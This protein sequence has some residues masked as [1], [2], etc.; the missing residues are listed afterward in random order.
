MAYWNKQHWMRRAPCPGREVLWQCHHFLSTDVEELPLSLLWYF[1]NETELRLCQHLLKP[2]QV[3]LHQHR[4]MRRERCTRCTITQTAL[5]SYLFLICYKRVNDSFHHLCSG[6]KGCCSHRLCF[7]LQ[8]CSLGQ[9]KRPRRRH[10]GERW[11]H[12]AGH[13]AVIPPALHPS[14]QSVHRR[15]GWMDWQENGRQT[16]W[17]FPT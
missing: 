6:N 14:V 13:G 9:G 11:L 5:S 8:L 10:P 2:L 4:A 17:T 7:Q 1:F 16:V 3:H 12:G 15:Q